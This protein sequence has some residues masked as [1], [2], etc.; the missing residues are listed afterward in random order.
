MAAIDA[1][2]WDALQH[3]VGEHLANPPDVPTRSAA[4][5]ASLIRA[6]VLDCVSALD[7]L[8]AALKQERRQRPTP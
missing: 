7:Q 3:S 8:H 5:N 2:D 4:L 1:A 6:A